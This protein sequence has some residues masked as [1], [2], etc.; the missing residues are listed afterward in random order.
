M[1]S[2]LSH[3]AVLLAIFC[4]ASPAISIPALAAGAPE[5]AV[6]AAPSLPAITVSKVKMITM[7]DRVYAGGLVQAVQLVQVAPLIEGQP[8]EALMVD[9]G[10][11]VTEGQVLARLSKTTLELMRSQLLAS[12]ASARATIAQA[13]AQVVE[14]Q[15][16]AEEANRVAA[17]SKLLLGQ[18]NVSQ[19]ATDQVRAAAVSATARVTV[20]QQSLEAAR[21]QQT[22]VEAQLANVELSLTRTEVIAPATGEILS[23][24]AEIG[25]IASAAGKP[26]F[27]LVRDGALE[28][29]AEIAERDLVRLA[30]GQV[31]QIAGV[32]LAAPLTGKVRLVEPSIDVATRLG[33]A[34]IALDDPSSMRA[35]MYADAEIILARRDTLAVPVTAVSAG[36]DGATVMRVTDGIAER[37][38]VQTGIRDSGQVE[39]LSGLAAGD[40]VVTKAGAFVRPG[41]RIQPVAAET[42]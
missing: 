21:A 14:A 20:A 39:I 17:R 12:V 8:I 25:S 15:A 19:A 10:D 29:R 4:A 11:R 7:T 33:H 6:V 40:T 16:S 42:N 38:V 41:D 31:A 27:T 3:K 26:M 22:N 36:A 1:I 34:R 30:A 35:G 5:P 2:T 28:L 23:R 24:N 37:V 9:I 32:G 18:G 13:E